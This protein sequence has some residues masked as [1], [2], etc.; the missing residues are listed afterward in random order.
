MKDKKYVYHGSPTRS[1]EIATPKRNIRSQISKTT[2]EITNIFDDISFHATPYKWIGLAYTYDPKRY[3]IEGRI[4][5]YNVGVS[6][7]DN[8]K[9]ITI[10]G[11]E[12]L[13]KSLGKLYGDGGYL[14]VFDKNKFFHKQGLGNLEVI[15][16]EPIE[17]L[18]IEKIDDPVKELKMLGVEFEYVDLSKL[19]NEQYR[20]Y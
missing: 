7:Y 11:Y 14:Y 12:S 6:L 10:F 16:K 5:R 15:T 17:P 13:E 3:K 18:L 8:N 1:F 20:N 2:G 9:R 19:E 4:S